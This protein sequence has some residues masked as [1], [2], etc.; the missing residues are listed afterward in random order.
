MMLPG[1]T[2]GVLGGGQLGRMLILEAIHY[3][4]RT[5]VLTDEGKDSP[6][7][8]L[9][10]E[11]FVGSYTDEVLVEQFLAAVDIV[12]VEFENIPDTCLQQ[13]AKKKVLSPS[14]DVIYTT[15]HRE[16]EKKFLR[17]HQIACAPFWIVDS[18][19]SLK[20][21]MTQNQG[22]RGVLKTAEFGY[23]GRGQIKLNGDEDAAE[24]WKLLDC[25][26]AVLESWV[27]YVKEISV[28]GARNQKGESVI[29]GCVENLHDRHILDYTLAPARVDVEVS[30]K[31]QQLWQ[32]VAEA[33]NY[34]GFFALE[35]F[36][37]E[38]GE[39]IVN[40]IAPRPHNS[41]HYSI[42]ACLT[43]QFELQLQ[44]ITG[45]PFG[46]TTQIMPAVMANLLGDVWVDSVTGE[47]H[48][49]HLFATANTK[50]HLYGKSEARERRK[51]GHFTVMA[52]TVE[53][54][55]SQAQALRE[56]L[57]KG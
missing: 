38:N 21:A 3:G 46:K 36:V 23:D 57:V 41:G 54:A 19:E 35:L 8:L 24:I 9:A 17:E 25:P 56:R 15:Q 4:Y 1:K 53:E 37:L 32:K 45:I 30:L 10:D 26:R 29:L 6:A 33:L 2:I 31:A 47:P 14:R 5:C 48:W 40:E 22:Q 39:V 28:L 34:V 20:M 51:M 55:L 13:I 43:N 7:A 44:A 18:A 27:P 16:R 12:T 50:L 52:P 11:V 42:E 49:Q